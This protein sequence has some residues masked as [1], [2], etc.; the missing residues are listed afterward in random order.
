M[1]QSI[2]PEIKLH[3]L[4]RNRFFFISSSFL[5]C[6][7]LPFLL[8]HCTTVKSQISHFSNDDVEK[9]LDTR[10]TVIDQ[11]ARGF[12]WLGTEHGLY[13]YDGSNYELI[14]QRDTSPVT[15]I[16][17]AQRRIWVGYQD[18]TIKWL[19][20]NRDL[21]T[22]L[23]EEG[24]PKV[25]ITGIKVDDTGRL[26]Y[27]T[28]GEGLYVQ[29]EKHVY[30]FNVEDGLLENQIYQMA[31]DSLGRLWVATDNGVSICQY[32]FSKKSIINLTRSDG[33]VDEIVYSLTAT[34]EGMWL[35][36]QSNG[37]C[38]IDNDLSLPDYFS[39]E[40][41]YGSVRSICPVVGNAIWVGTESSGLIEGQLLKSGAYEFRQIED[42]NSHECNQI[43][44]DHT[45]N[46]WFI[47]DHHLLYHG[48]GNLRIFRSSIGD[49]QSICEG[50]D[51][52]IWIGTRNGLYEL[53]D[54]N[55]EKAGWSKEN[56]ISLYADDDGKIWIGTFGDGII[57]WDPQ[58][59][60]NL[61]LTESQ[62]LV[63]GS[64][65]SMDGF[66]NKLWLAT[67][68]GIVEIQNDRD[69]LSRGQIRYTNLKSDTELTSNFFYKVFV[70]HK[71]IV[72]LGTDGH[73]L[74]QIKH[75]DI[76]NLLDEG[77]LPA[78]TVY[79]MD[80]D[81][82][83]NIWI[84]TNNEGVFSFDGEQWEHL[85]LEDGLRN[86]TVSSIAV[87]RL[88][89]ILMVH[90]NGFDLYNPALQAFRYFDENTG[91]DQ[92]NPG[93]NV[94]NKDQRNSIWMGGQ[95][96]VVRYDVDDRIHRIY[97][98]L[99]I[100]QVRVFNEPIDYLNENQFGYKE[101]FIRFDYIGI[102]YA[103]SQNL[104][105][106]YQLDGY[107][108]DWKRTRDQSVSYSKLAPGSYTFKLR[109]VV[110]EQAINP[111]EIRYSFV[112]LR[113]FWQQ[114]WFIG[115]MAIAAVG[116][117]FGYQRYREQQINRR[118]SIE[119]ERIESQYEVLKA[120]INP[121]FLFNSFNTLAGIVEE[122]PDVAVEY[123]EKLSDYYRSIIQ[124]RN[125]K[126]IPLEAELV[127]I[128]DFTYLLKKRFSSNLIIDKN[129]ES[130][131]Y[132][133]P[134]LTLQMLV[135]NAVKHNIISR[136]KPLKISIRSQN[137]DYLVV[138]NNL[139][140]K[141]TKEPST[142]FGLQNIR[143]RFEILTRKK[144]VINQDDKSFSILIPLIKYDST[145]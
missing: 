60:K 77:R 82:S 57:C 100:D 107:D 141:K 19:E 130:I 76:S 25:A 117:F 3:R 62:G 102:W 7:C 13:R 66:E 121:H 14:G 94:T 9:I 12:I 32:T 99:I 10:L 105:F 2:L 95:N 4:G 58:S 120:Q 26:W 138:E 31:L 22:Y 50:K 89:N 6:L 90:E 136:Q 23:P 63:N 83:G 79:T 112:I 103:S 97:P 54:K 110:N 39:E 27:S 144:V 46:I 111:S 133:I 101:N 145:N 122:D 35:G 45:G 55:I 68:G 92:F 134:P 143:N 44:L 87:D 21:H 119:R 16:A 67:L 38:H 41:Q 113:P 48:V 127:L 81:A 142:K 78:K 129:I 140:P 64:V 139:Q 96:V 18:G 126:L 125:Q 118:A 40:W 11:D 30:N 53:Q 20:N 88:G 71:G 124:F 51:G 5:R 93:L 36:F 104:Q 47:L 28:Y 73:G 114:G 106:E 69:L 17:C 49:I 61:R 65:F 128:D 109:S 115:L 15:A 24:L 116:M 70:D 42:Q 52:R 135:E 8:L 80:Q 43:V 137:D 108:F 85:G 86:L 34:A 33:L 56:I 72:W 131:D 37:I 123:I 132:Y 1:W 29:D 59:D 74:L 98:N 91:L 84:G 75:R